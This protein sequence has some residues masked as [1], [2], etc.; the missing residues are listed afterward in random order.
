MKLLKEFWKNKERL[1]VL[2]CF[3]LLFIFYFILI[4]LIPKNQIY[5]DEIFFYDQAR[6]IYE[7]GEFVNFQNTQ[8]LLYPLFLSL[9]YKNIIVARLVNIL[10]MLILS[11]SKGAHNNKA[12]MPFGP[13]TEMMTWML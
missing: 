9:F 6:K 2:I 4:F 10:L 8:P 1:I 11:K 5:G 12:L 7:K 3:L 13:S